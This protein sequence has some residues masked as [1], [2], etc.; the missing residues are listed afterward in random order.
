MLKILLIFIIF[1]LILYIFYKYNNEMNHKKHQLI[2]Y[3]NNQYYNKNQHNH[4]KCPRGCSKN[5]KC[6][7][8]QYCYNSNPI[9]PI[10]C[11]NDNQ[12][13]NC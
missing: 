12:C 7:Y 5:K 10:C 11:I 2:F 9:S 4:P 1:I 13:N 3:L 6:M 8:S